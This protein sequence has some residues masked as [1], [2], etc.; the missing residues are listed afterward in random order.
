MKIGKFI[1]TLQSPVVVTNT[2]NFWIE[3]RK[4]LQGE[5]LLMALKIYKQ[6]TGMGLKEAKTHFDQIRHNFSAQHESPYTER[7]SELFVNRLRKIYAA[8]KRTVKK[9]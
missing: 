5:A 8:E 3:I 9:H 2:G 6:N 7:G 4:A 1:I